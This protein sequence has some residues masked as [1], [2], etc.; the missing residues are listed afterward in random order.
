MI[1]TN[2]INAIR[3]NRY[4]KVNSTEHKKKFPSLFAGDKGPLVQRRYILRAEKNTQDGISFIQTA[5]G[6][7]DETINILQRIREL[8]VKSANG[9][10]NNSDRA[11]IQA[12]VSNLIDEID[13]VASQAQ[14]NTLNILTGRFSNTVNASAS[15]WIHIGPSRDQRKRIYIATMTANSLKLKNEFNSYVSV[16]SVS[17]ANR[18]IGIIDEA[19][20]YVIKQRSDLGA[21]KN[22]FNTYI[23]GL[24]TSYENVI[25]Y[26]SK[27]MDRDV[28]EASIFEAISSIKSQ[29]ALAMLVHSNNLPKDALNLLR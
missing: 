24:M 7:L 1:I 26:G 20:G 12:E 3:A 2:N 11:Y 4:L 21:Y 6:Y 18:T 22:R 5:D 8:S 14:F 15:M 9:I 27:K 29:S 25:A 19:I 16:S 17:K 23:Q 13:R 10:Y 28:A